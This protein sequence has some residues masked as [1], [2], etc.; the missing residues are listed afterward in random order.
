MAFDPLDWIDLA[1]GLDIASEAA[2]RTAVSRYYY[3]VFMKSLLS[4]A[5]DGKIEPR[6][7]RTDHGA[8]ARAL[9][10][11]R[12]SAGGALE[13]LARLREAA[14]YDVTTEFTPLIVAEAREQALEVVRM[15]QSDWA[16]L[17]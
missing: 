15:C 5:H 10:V 7:D 4:L 17:P 3:A 9:R 12:H 11:N 14:D 8:V 2:C 16:S 13:R 6:G 1:A